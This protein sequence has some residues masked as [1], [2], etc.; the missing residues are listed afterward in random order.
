M[1]TIFAFNAGKVIMENATV[2]ETM[3][4]PSDTT[5]IHQ[6]I[7]ITKKL[8][9]ALHIQGYGQIH[10]V[11]SENLT[12]TIYSGRSVFGSSGPHRN[13]RALSQHSTSAK[14]SEGYQTKREKCPIEN[15]LF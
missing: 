4:H 8:T 12:T 2:K 7:H 13:F 11:K 14:I 5:D 1:V 9:Y 15:Y 3:D 6:T 10:K